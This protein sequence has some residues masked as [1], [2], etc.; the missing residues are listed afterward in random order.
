MTHKVTVDDDVYLVLTTLSLA[1]GVSI[2][3]AITRIAESKPPAEA[4]DD[5]HDNGA[6]P[7]HAI[8]FGTRTCGF[9][10]PTTRHLTVTDGP[11]QGTYKSPSGASRAV[12]QALNPA[13]SPVRTGWLFWKITATGEPLNTLRHRP[14]LFTGTNHLPN[15]QT[16]APAPSPEP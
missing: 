10:D 16:P 7:V 12:L 14:R 13:V 3:E 1:W 15:P 4:P 11:A 2:S 9:F 6:V 5:N 8:Y